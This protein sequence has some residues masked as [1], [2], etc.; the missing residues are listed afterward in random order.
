MATLLLALSLATHNPYHWT[1]T[2]AR[3]QEVRLEVMM[4]PHLDYRAKLNIIRHLR[5][6]VAERCDSVLV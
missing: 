2:C 3:W 6:K 4:D 5:S 1:M